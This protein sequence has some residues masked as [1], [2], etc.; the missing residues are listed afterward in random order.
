MKDA[1]TEHSHTWVLKAH[2]D[3]CH[4]FESFF[5]CLCGAKRSSGA[6]RDLADDPYSAI[7]M[8]DE[9]CER[10]QELLAGAKPS[11]W[12]EVLPEG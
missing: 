9:D 5:T 6:E 10:C 2:I 7:W 3:G 12:D 4:S 1:V 11:S 8:Q